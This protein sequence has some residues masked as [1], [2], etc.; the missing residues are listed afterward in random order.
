M[1]SALFLSRYD[2]L[3]FKSVRNVGSHPFKGT[4]TVGAIVIGLKI[5][6]ERALLYHP[7][8]RSGKLR[9]LVDPGP[10]LVISKR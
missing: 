10:T 6:L 1:G 3:I 9:S 7:R 8:N 2:Y 5:R 4:V